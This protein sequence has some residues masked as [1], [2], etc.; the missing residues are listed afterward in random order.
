[1]VVLGRLK[2]WLNRRRQ[3]AGAQPAPTLLERYHHYK[4]L[5]A[6]NAAILSILADLQAKLAEDYVFDMAYVRHAVTRLNRETEILVEALIALSGGRYQDLREA[7]ERVAARLLEELA[8]PPIRPGPLALPLSRVSEGHSFGG[9]AEKLGELKR[10]GF[11]VPRGFAVNAYAQK[12]F[13]STPAWRISS[14]RPFRRWTSGTWPAWSG[15]RRPSGSAW[16]PPR[17]RQ[18]SPRP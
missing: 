8:P 12:L 13:S 9:K 18:T 10:L 4:R 3:T 7:R 17:C 6:A 1:M 5:L 14:G 2:A 16:W 11:P 15:P